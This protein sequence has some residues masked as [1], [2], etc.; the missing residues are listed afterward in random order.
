MNDIG[1]QW[2]V[3][4]QCL[5]QGSEQNEC[6]I[7]ALLFRKWKEGATD[8]NGMCAYFHFCSGSLEVASAFY[9]CE[10]CHCRFLKCH[11]SFS[12]SLFSPSRLNPLSP[13]LPPTVL[14]SFLHALNHP[15]CVSAA[16]GVDLR[17]LSQIKK[18]EGYSLHS[19][20]YLRWQKT[21]I[22]HVHR[23][24]HTSSSCRYLIRK[25]YDCC[26]AMTHKAAVLT[27]A[28]VCCTVLAG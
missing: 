14:P 10:L 8:F 17:L 6:R 7:F 11:P 20:Q 16:S 13:P 23:R 4:D 12:R 9:F 5:L 25:T 28:Y 26:F 2:Q 22:K 27:H 3:D 24:P 15:L 19:L 1:L 18:K 21:H